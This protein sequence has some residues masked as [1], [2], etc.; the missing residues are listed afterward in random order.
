MNFDV[1]A[2]FPVD[3]RLQ[4]LG[5]PNN[6]SPYNSNK[7]DN[8]NKR[9]RPKALSLA[10]QIRVAQTAGEAIN[11]HAVV[12]RDRK[13]DRA[14]SKLHAKFHRLCAAQATPHKLAE[15]TATIDRVGRVTRVIIKPPDTELSAI[16]TGVAKLFGLSPRMVR[17][18][19]T[20]PRM[21]PFMPHP[22]WIERDWLRAGRLEFAA[23]QIAT[24][25]LPPEQWSRR[26]EICNGTI[27]AVDPADQ[28]IEHRTQLLRRAISNMRRDPTTLDHCPHAARFCGGNPDGRYRSIEE[29]A[30]GIC[31]LELETYRNARRNAHA[32]VLRRP[33]ADD[34][35]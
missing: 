17:R 9:G 11:A 8:Y 25:L 12:E 32:L 23:R 22:V 18:C 33:G 1:Y 3:Y 15:V 6:L 2:G 26:F 28:H 31:W 16:D 13:R 34:L 35:G 14:I 20:D 5:L 30:T 4:L 27:R 29:C 7:R 24:R 21:R 10:E 19:R